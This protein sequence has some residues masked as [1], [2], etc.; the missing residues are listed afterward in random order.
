MD[1]NTPTH[2][3]PHK[4]RGDVEVALDDL[5][6]KFVSDVFTRDDGTRVLFHAQ[7]L[8]PFDLPALDPKLAG[9]VNEKLS[10]VEPTS[11]KDY[12]INFKSSTAICLAS[13][14]SNQ[15]VAVLDYHGR[16]RE[17]GDAATPQRKAHQ[18][19]L[20]CPWDIDYAKW[21]DIFGKGMTQGDFAN[22]LEE[23]VHTIAEP[24]VADLAEAIDDLR[25]DRSVR[26]KSKVNRRNGS[27]QFT[28]EDTENPGGE[29]GGEFSLPE[30]VKIVL[31]M[32]QGGELIQLEAKLRYNVDKG[33]V[34]FTLVVPGLDKLER[35]QFRRIGEDVRSSTAT[36]VFYTT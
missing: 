18:V 17:G 16:A 19:T 29:G 6:S 26:V 13:L 10:L 25:I 30:V 12:I 21:R 11:F 2:A 33:K 36:P 9:F 22:V 24:A 3:A 14:G 7:D 28:Y 23:L 1:R 5:G 20:L 8:K 32:F 4:P 31:P 27:V 15:I 34:Y 35:D